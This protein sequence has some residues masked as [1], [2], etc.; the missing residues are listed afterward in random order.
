MCNH[1]RVAKTRFTLDLLNLFFLFRQH[2]GKYIFGDP[3]I[4]RCLYQMLP[5]A[6]C[7]I[8]QR[9]LLPT[10]T[11]RKAADNIHVKSIYNKQFLSY[12]YATGIAT[13]NGVQKL[14]HLDL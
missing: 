8:F 2:N 14:L 13:A 4:P 7:E 5:G 1:L 12:L 3:L 10:Q 11:F 6:K 9:C